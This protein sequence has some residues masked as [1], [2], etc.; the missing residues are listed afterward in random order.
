[1][2]KLIYPL[3]TLSIL[4]T[5]GCEDEDEAVDC[6]ALLT[7]LQEHPF[8]DDLNTLMTTFE[9]PDSYVTNCNAF[10]DEVQSMI[11]KGCDF[12]DWNA[13]SVTAVRNESC[14]TTFTI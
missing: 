8:T 5:I 12:E 9:F 7:T 3:V 6:E 1:M 14:D 2:K 10:Y 13:D 4:F 11:D